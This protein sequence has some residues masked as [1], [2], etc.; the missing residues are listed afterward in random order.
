MSF[1]FYN[2]AA[3]CLTGLMLGGCDTNPPYAGETAP[4]KQAATVSP[5]TN[6]KQ[7]PIGSAR[8]RHGCLY[9]TQTADGK[10]ARGG[11][12]PKGK[13]VTIYRRTSDGWAEIGL[14]R[15]RVVSVPLEDLATTSQFSRDASRASAARRKPF[16]DPRPKVDPAARLR[17]GSSLLPPPGPPPEGFV[18]P[19]LPDAA[20][21]PAPL[22]EGP[23]VLFPEKKE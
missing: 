2:M 14:G 9:Y 16:P 22:Q 20:T 3:V 5:V 18:P 1:S 12:L 19:A 21:D 10:M 8:V 6:E 15:G 23:S 7:R 4:S 13:R 17:S 11:S